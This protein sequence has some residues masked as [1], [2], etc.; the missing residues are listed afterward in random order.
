MFRIRM[1]IS[2]MYSGAC[3]Y[4]RNEHKTQ[5]KLVKLTFSQNLKLVKIYSWHKQ[6]C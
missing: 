5:C 2:V 6:A 1:M 4:W 3:F